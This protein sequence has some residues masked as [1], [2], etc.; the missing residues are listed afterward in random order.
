MNEITIHHQKSPYINPLKTGRRLNQK[1]TQFEHWL[2]WLASVVWRHRCSV[3]CNIH[4]GWSPFKRS[5]PHLSIWTE[6]NKWT[7]K[8]TQN[9]FIVVPLCIMFPNIW[10][11]IYNGT[12]SCINHFIM[13][14][15]CLIFSQLLRSVYTG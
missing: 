14:S 15:V 9:H 3:T 12:S 10:R 13:V 8:V 6:K 7:H 1:F 2:N 11:S 4:S 5:K